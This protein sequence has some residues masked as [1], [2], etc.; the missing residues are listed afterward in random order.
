MNL[1][2]GAGRIEVNGVRADVERR[3]T[4]NERFEAKLQKSPNKGD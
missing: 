4:M 1:G 3:S 2:A